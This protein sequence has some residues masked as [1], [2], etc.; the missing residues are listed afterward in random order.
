MDRK[1]NALE[2]LGSGGDLCGRI[3]LSTQ[4]GLAQQRPALWP[5]NLLASAQDVTVR[6][7]IRENAK[8]FKLKLLLRQI[9]IPYVK[10]LGPAQNL[11]SVA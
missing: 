5:P 1:H 10:W 9:A 7:M 6:A 8:L 2:P 4:G 3:R 11:S